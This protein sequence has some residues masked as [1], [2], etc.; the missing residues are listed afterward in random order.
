MAGFLPLFLTDNLFLT[1]TP[2]TTSLLLMV[3]YSI[4]LANDRK[5][6]TFFLL[7]LFYFLA[8][9][10]KATIALYPIVL[11]VYFILKKYPLKVALKQ[12]GVA[13]ILLLLVLG[14]WWARNYIHYEQFIP[15]TGGGGNP[16]LLG[17]YQGD[18]YKYGDPYQ[19]TIDRIA[20]DESLPNNVLYRMQAQ[21]EVAKERLSYW[22]ND[23]PSSFIKSFVLTKTEI[24]WDSQFYWIEV[25][26]VSSQFMN[27]IHL[28]IVQMALWSLIGLIFIRKWIKEYILIIGIVLYNTILNSINFAFDRYN[29]PMMFVLF[30]LIATSIYLI[31]KLLIRLRNRFS[32]SNLPDHN[33]KETLR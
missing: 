26:S 29:Q 24:Q 1:E 16:L 4:R 6:S 21:Q 25:Y 5:W 11:L 7:M 10:F 12:L 27:E 19:E 18:G 23:D 14:P 22:W 32:K 9:F 2:F 33:P 15:L 3:Y 17:S 31:V 20:N 8:L 28:I 30:I 13:T